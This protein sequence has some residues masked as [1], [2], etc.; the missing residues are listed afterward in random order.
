MIFLMLVR[1]QN[2]VVQHITVYS[3]FWWRDLKLANGMATSH[4]PGSAIANFVL[5][6]V[7]I[8]ISQE[9]SKIPS[10]LRR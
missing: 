7:N 3:L 5:L 9:P 6:G 10:K 1:L 4:W 2:N 8:D